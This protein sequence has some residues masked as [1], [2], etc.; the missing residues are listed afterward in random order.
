ML[1]TD[2]Y[3]DLTKKIKMKGLSVF[4]WVILISVS[5]IAWFALVLYAIP[6]ALLLFLILFTFEYFDEDIYSILI[7]KMNIKSNKYYA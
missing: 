7:K 2:C 5:F 3:R 4:S 6:I 1:Q